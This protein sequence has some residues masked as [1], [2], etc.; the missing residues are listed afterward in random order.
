[1][2]NGET[3]VKLCKKKS[4]VFVFFGIFFKTQNRP[5]FSN[6]D[7]FKICVGFKLSE[8]CVSMQ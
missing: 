8:R 4:G 6:K 5:T 1:M 2:F 3:I 7:T